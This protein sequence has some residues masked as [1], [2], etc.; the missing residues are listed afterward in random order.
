MMPRKVF[1]MNKFSD[2]SIYEIATKYEPLELEFHHKPNYNI[3]LHWKLT[4]PLTLM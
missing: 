4:L 3:N 1:I 2:E